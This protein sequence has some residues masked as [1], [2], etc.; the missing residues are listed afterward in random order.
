MYT[1]YTALCK[2]PDA[3][4]DVT[5]DGEGSVKEYEF[6]ELCLMFPPADDMTIEEM[7][8]DIQTN[9]LK[10][11]VVIYEGKILDGRNRYLACRKAGLEPKTVEYKGKDPLGFVISK[12]LHRRHLTPAQ[13]S[14]IAANILAEKGPKATSADRALLARQMEV[15]E[16]MVK[17]AQRINHLAIDPIKT[18]LNSG[19]LSINKAN[20]ILNEARDR[21]DTRITNNTVHPKDEKK[22]KR[23]QRKIFCTDVIDKQPLLFEEAEEYAPGML[24]GIKEAKK[25]RKAVMDIQTVITK[26]TEVPSMFDEASNIVG[27][28]DQE[29]LLSA[30]LS[31]MQRT[32][33]D[34]MAKVQVNPVSYDDIFRYTAQILNERFK[35]PDF[36]PSDEHQLLCELRDSFKDQC[37]DF[38]SLV[39]RIKRSIRNNGKFIEDN[40]DNDDAE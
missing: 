13:K 19:R 1:G 27:A 6:H 24:T 38:L 8:F 3:T 14:M 37:E 25:F 26:I 20:T 12:N 31:V 34:V 11:P 39:S 17:I 23:A 35:M 7:S 33:R 29:K 9:G 2:T 22:F 28:L 16:S 4:G 10:D 5:K 32:V 40:V 36:D 18:M 21:T 15:G 30:I